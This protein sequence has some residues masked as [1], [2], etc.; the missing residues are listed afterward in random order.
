ME[1]IQYF[2]LTFIVS[3]LFALGGVGGAA[4]LVPLLNMMGLPFGLSKALGLFVNS[5]ST[6]VATIMNLK[7]KVLD[8]RFAFPLAVS[9]MLFTPV[10][11]YLSQYVDEKIM[12][13]M[14]AGF[15]FFSASMILFGKKKVKTVY[16]K[17]WILYFIGIVVGVF[18]GMVGVGG[19]SMILPLLIMLGYNPKKMA[20]AVSFIIPFSTFTAFLMYASIIK[21][22]YR[23]LVITSTAAILGGY[24]GNRI[25]HFKL[26]S[27]QIKKIIAILLYLI[28]IKLVYTLI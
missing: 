12:K 3:T 27:N 20:I 9:L 15:L 17:Q 18:S 26:D 24:V 8:V 1:Y 25:M 4:A 28:V 10:G 16:T 7:R 5:S 11:A 6:I 13:W 22:D 19:G 2:F 21:I 14:L 23:L